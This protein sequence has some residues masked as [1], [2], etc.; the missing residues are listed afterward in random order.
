MGQAL[1]DLAA[2]ASAKAERVVPLFIAVDPER[3]TNSVLKD[4]VRN[5]HPRLIGLTGAPEQIDRVAQ[6]Y[7]A[8]HAPVPISGGDYMG[9]YMMDHSGFIL[10]MGPA[11][12][13]LTHFES[14]AQVT[15]LVEELERRIKE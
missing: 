3:D 1:D 8:F 12:E 14:D 6:D 15:E 10:L 11:G 13:Y 2:H 4:Y 9:D 7:G 5:F